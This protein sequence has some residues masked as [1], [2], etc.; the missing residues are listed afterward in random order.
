MEESPSSR[1]A[2]P[3]SCPQVRS[4]SSRGPRGLGL[5]Q[6]SRIIPKKLVKGNEEQVFDEMQVLKDLDHPNIVSRLAFL[7]ANGYRS[8]SPSSYL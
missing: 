8:Y 3:R 5:I 6:L 1:S 4:H 2:S 7:V